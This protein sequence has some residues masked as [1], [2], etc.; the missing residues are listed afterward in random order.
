VNRPILVTSALPYANGPSHIGR[1]T[2]AYL[3]ADIYVRYQRLK[4]RD[5]L[6]I[7][8]SD[9]H[10]VPITIQAEKEGVTP[11]AL[12]DRYTAT[13]Q[14]E[15]ARMGISFDFYSRTSK[16]I[17][18]E[19]AREIFLDLLEKDLL[20]RKPEM[21]WFDEKAG[22]FLSDRYVE[23][24]CP[25]CQNPEA[26]GDQC[27]KCGTYLNQMDLKDPRSKVTGT[28]PVARE[29]TH[30]YLPMGDFQ[31]ALEKWIDTKTHWKDNVINYCKGWFAQRLSDRAITRDID[32]GVKVP[33]HDRQGRPIEGAERKVI[34]VW[35]EAV[36]GY[37]SATKDWAIANGKPDAWKHYWENPDTQLVH[38]IGKDNI[39][40]HAIMFPIIA[41]AYNRGK[42]KGQLAL[43]SDVP[44][45]EFLNLEGAKLSTSRNY[46]V[47]VKDYLEK[48]PP[49][50]LRYTLTCNLP[51]TKDTDFSWKDFQAKNNNELADILGNF[52]NRSLAFVGRQFDNKVPPRGKLDA[53]DRHMLDDIAKTRD[54]VGQYLESFRFRDACRAFMDLAR[55]ANKYFNDSEPWKTVKTDRARCATTLNVS[56]AVSRAL[57]VIMHP[58][59][60]FTADKVWRMLNLPGKVT[61]V[62]WDEVGKTEMD[63]GHALGQAEILFT[64]IDDGVIRSEIDALKSTI[65]EKKTAMED[66]TTVTIDDFKKLDLRTGTVLSA[67]KIKGSDKL[68]R[69]DVD[70][71]TEKRQIVSGLALHYTPEQMVGKQVI[72]ITNLK[73]AVIRGVESRGMLL[74]AGDDTTLRILTPE[75]AV[76]PGAR[77]S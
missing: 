42:T 16:P 26:R 31:D 75:A 49:D 29:T 36:L 3:P 60:P 46:A 6:Y 15:F 8:G 22:M 67:E 63:E 72:V 64:K 24:T 28:R 74:T 37:I 50:P 73:P 45:C 17:H 19:T 38:F 71:G 1:L 18:H 35:F 27:E 7:C 57:A 12:V 58:F 56:I 44:A 41:M 23:G 33:Q 25:V 30:F 20:K 39:V 21:Q 43:V 59:I 13:I 68:L 32:W 10:G 48:F 69:L 5:I 54:A 61:D 77:I 65:V 47:W 66:E 52:I 34:Y 2:G 53:V 4:R 70:L 14:D 9:E 11:Q 51:E 76:P 55:S 62:A 40:F